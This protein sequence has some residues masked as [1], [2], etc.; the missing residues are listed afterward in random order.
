MK[1]LLKELQ[2]AAEELRNESEIAIIEKYAC[3][4]KRFNIVLIRKTK[5]IQFSYKRQR[6][7]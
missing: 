7:N 5:F 1:Y 3:K 4:G 6:N 2:H